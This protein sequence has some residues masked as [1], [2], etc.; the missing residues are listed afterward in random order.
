MQYYVI[1]T[2][3]RGYYVGFGPT[4]TKDWWPRFRW[5]IPASYEEVVRFCTPEQARAELRHLR[6]LGFKLLTA[7]RIGGR[8]M[9]EGT[10]AYVFIYER[11]GEVKQLR[12]EYDPEDDELMQNEAHGWELVEAYHVLPDG[13]QVPMM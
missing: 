3:S 8:D 1:E 12:Y 5:S 9:E 7:R 10:H 6:S 2:P 13:S 4:Q 11:D